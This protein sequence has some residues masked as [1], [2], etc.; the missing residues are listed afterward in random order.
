MGQHFCPDSQW[1]NR[2]KTKS[3]RQLIGNETNQFFYTS[4]QGSEHWLHPT[5]NESDCIYLAVVYFLCVQ[6]NI[7]F[8]CN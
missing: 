6:H 1:V 7:T 3:T 4:N 5:G 2:C 8:W